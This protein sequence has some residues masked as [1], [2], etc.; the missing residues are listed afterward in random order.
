M[1]DDTLTVRHETPSD[2]ELVYEI[3]VA[4]FGQDNEARLVEA[5]YEADHVVL[6]LVAEVEGEVV[7]HVLFSPMTVGTETDTNVAICLGPMAVAPSYQ[8]QG[9][10]TRLVEIALAELRSLVSTA[11]FLVGDAAFYSRFGFRPAREFDVHYLDDPDAFMALGL[12]P[13]ALT[14]ISGTARFAPEFDRFV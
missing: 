10:G 11:V 2:R 6:S 13:S 5:L 14:Y 12:T 4:A 3:A 1:N 9:I 7:G 8:N